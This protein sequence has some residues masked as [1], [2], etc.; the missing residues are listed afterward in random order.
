MLSILKLNLRE[1]NNT[2]LNRS[3]EMMPKFKLRWSNLR[4]PTSNHSATPPP[5]EE[6]LNQ[7]VPPSGATT[8]G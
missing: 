7:C 2:G 5:H 3:E 4:A 8:K 6:E 1:A